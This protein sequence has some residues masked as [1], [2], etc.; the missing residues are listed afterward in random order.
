MKRIHFNAKCVKC[1]MV[2]EEM[3]TIGCFM[4]CKQC[5]DET[6]KTDDPPRQE[7]EQYVKWLSIYNRSF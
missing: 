2:E 5:A 4:M 3:V 7:R 1:D 6:F